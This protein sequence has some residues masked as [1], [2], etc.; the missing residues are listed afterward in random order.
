MIFYAQTDKGI[1][2]AGNE[3]SFGYSIPDDL[4]RGF[5]VVADGLG[6]R[7]AGEIASG[8]TADVLSSE[9]SA[10]Y[11]RGGDIS[12]ISSVYKTAYQKANDAVIESSG[13][14]DSRTGMATTAVCAYIDGGKAVIA[15]VGDSR[16]YFISKF[17][18]RQITVDHSY[19]QDLVNLGHISQKEAE[20]H[21]RKNEITRA[22]GVNPTVA[23]D[24]F[25]KN[26]RYGDMILLCTDGLTRMLS[27]K[28]IYKIIRGNFS[29]PGKIP[30]KLIDQ[31]NK[32]GGIDNITVSLIVL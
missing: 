19:V 30:Q 25:V 17:S 6:G 5:F 27:D 8:I 23:P 9:F 2:R 31:A 32:N 21:P 13:E 28:D 24:L 1:K 20:N 14:D 12:E 15:N 16:A 7:K 18:V 29:D 26:A 4:S 3:D 11:E 10:F 22:I